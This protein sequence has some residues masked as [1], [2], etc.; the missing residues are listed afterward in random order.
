MRELYA[1]ED[2]VPLL[3]W[4]DSA[5]EQER[6]LELRRR[7]RDARSRPLVAALREW[8]Y[9]IKPTP[10]P[11]S[12]I[13]LAV[14]DMLGLRPGRMRCL[15][16]PRIPI[17]HNATERATRAPVAGRKNP[18]GSRSGRGIEVAALFY[19]LSE[20]AR[21]CSGLASRLTSSG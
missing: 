7:L 8:G 20:S 5:V 12:G 3:A 9:A 13:G 11:K 17:D 18:Y 4:G 14:D 6:T 19:T 16:T 2:E 21:S 15:A 1:V 10:L